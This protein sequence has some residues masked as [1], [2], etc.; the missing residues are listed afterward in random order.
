VFGTYD[1]DSNIIATRSSRI[2]S[3]LMSFAEEVESSDAFRGG[4]CR[5]YL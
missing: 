1:L 3:I 5:T 4:A 2:L